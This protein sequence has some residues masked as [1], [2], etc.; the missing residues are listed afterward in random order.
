MLNAKNIY[1]GYTDDEWV[2]DNV[3]LSVEPGEIV[4][5]VGASGVGKSTLL[6][7]LNGR[8]SWQ[9]GQISVDGERL[10]GPHEQLLPGHPSIA[11]VDQTFSRDLHFTVYE[12]IYNQ[13]L[14]LKQ[15]DREEF[16]RELIALFDLEKVRNQQSKYLS[17]GEQQRLSMA[18][19]LAT[20]PKYLLLDEPFSHLDAHLKQTIGDYL[21]A[22]IQVRKLGVLFVSHDGQEALS[23][24]DRILLM[25]K[26][27]PMKSY[28]P[29]K[30]Y[31]D[32]D[33]YQE[34]R[35]F[36]VLNK[37]II[38]GEE[39]M[40]RPA[41]FSL[42]STTDYRRSCP[43]QYKSSNFHG[44]YWSNLFTLED[45]NE[46]VLHAEKKLTTVNKIYV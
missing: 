24:S 20:E 34:G 37:I 29:E 36:G 10:K 8:I 42:Q 4:G 44:P 9:S 19:A 1:A 17:G 14:H 38:A 5:I 41:A 6:N 23:W 27:Q 12:N 28:S 45:G 13:L 32:P 35:F 15:T 26:D 39:L 30:A 18:S 2:L 40:F 21:R 3:S 25:Q 16:C 7:C 33:N 31:H 43:V 11:L 22:L 46:I